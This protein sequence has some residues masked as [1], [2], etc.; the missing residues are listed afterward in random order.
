MLQKC[1][2]VWAA[3][4]FFGMA[5][6][7]HMPA[8]PPIAESVTPSEAPRLILISIDGFRADY[9][10]EGITPNLQA[11]ADGGASA[12]MR[13]SFPSLTFPNHYTLVTGLRPI[14]MASSITPCAIRKSRMSL[15]SCRTGKP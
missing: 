9:L 13:P 8:S 2:R 11:L 1:L 10:K 12:A 5:A 3:L 6:C 4:A 15:S 14:I 7:S